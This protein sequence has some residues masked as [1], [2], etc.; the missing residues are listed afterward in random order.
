MSTVGK[1]LALLDALSGA[2]PGLGLSEIARLCGTDKATARRLLVELG[3]HGFVEQD[4]LSRKY[5]I[6]AA[7]VRLA[8]IREQRF[9]FL[10][11]STPIAD[12]LSARAGETV[13]VS[14]FVGGRLSTIHVAEAPRGHRVT[15][16]VGSILP[17]HATA[18]GLA[19]L[20][21]SPEPELDTLLEAKLP[22]YTEHTVT[23]RGVLLGLVGEAR[24]RGYSICLQGI[25]HGTIS[26][27][28]AIRLGGNRPIGTIALAA[29]LIR[30]D[31]T[32][33][34]AL[35]LQVVEA[36]AMIAGRYF[37]ATAAEAGA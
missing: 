33:I 19:F 37:G 12:A 18:S 36:A 5:D 32:A 10:R 15:L 34:H 3:R 17:M 1:A 28:A 16:D 35:G 6:G 4:P 9:P 26:T 13:H 8:R 21:A 7:P 27:G 31:E 11:I 29:P 25:E 2:E 20:A 23:D 30:I 22:A 24:S 14:K